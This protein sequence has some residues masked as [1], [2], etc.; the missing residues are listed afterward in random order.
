MKQTKYE[1]NRQ[2]INERRRDLMSNNKNNS[3]EEIEE[4]VQKARD[5]GKNFVYHNGTAIPVCGIF[6][7]SDKEILAKIVHK[8]EESINRN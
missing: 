5:A 4:K 7:K 2:V 1:F 6:T 3:K 8:S